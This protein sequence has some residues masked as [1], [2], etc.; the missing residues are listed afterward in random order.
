MYPSCIAV[1]FPQ[2]AALRSG[3]SLQ[4]KQWKN[5]DFHIKIWIAKTSILTKA[6]PIHP[7]PSMAL[8][9][10]EQLEQLIR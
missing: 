6:Y 7:W 9:V 8:H 1:N 10:L 5:A 4:A 3:W 2:S